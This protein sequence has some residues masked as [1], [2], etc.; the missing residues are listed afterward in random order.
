MEISHISDNSSERS[1]DFRTGRHEGEPSPEKD[2][3][4]PAWPGMPL[5]LEHLSG[6][7]TRSE[8]RSGSLTRTKGQLSFGSTGPPVADVSRLGP[9]DDNLNCMKVVRKNGRSHSNL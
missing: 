4:H 6:F 7:S 9:A 2:I 3:Y 8:L 1:T 5:G